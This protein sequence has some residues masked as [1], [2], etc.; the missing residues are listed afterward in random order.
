M[1]KVFKD[2]PISEITLRRFE[3]PFNEDIDSLTRKFCISLGLLQPGDSR[4][5][6][7]DVFK[8][9]LVSAKQKKVLSS[10]QVEEH[11]KSKNKEGI[12]GSNVR[13]QLLR[14][15][16]IGLVEKFDGGYRMKEFMSLSEIFNG[17]VKRFIL[18]PITERIEEYAA[19][20]DKKI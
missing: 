17:N 1:G 7:V 5:I 13:R 3:R 6:V 18:N 20:L 10:T 15:E 9:L 14:L 4:D 19:E 11:L 2:K 16:N 8:L 12:S